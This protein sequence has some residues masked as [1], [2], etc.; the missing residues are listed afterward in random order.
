LLYAP[1][2]IRSGTEALAVFASATHWEAMYQ[3]WY[4]G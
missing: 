4:Q 2:V 3:A 1:Q